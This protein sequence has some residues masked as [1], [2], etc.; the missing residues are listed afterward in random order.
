VTDWNPRDI[1]GETFEV[2][3]DFLIRVDSYASLV[4]HRYKGNVPEDVLREL[5]RIATEAQKL[6]GASR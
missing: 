3:G 4:V 6:Y 2:S 1:S 5:D